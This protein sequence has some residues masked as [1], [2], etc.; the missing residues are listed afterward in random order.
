MIYFDGKIM[1]TNKIA[2]KALK[3][4]LFRIINSEFF[5]FAF[6]HSILHASKMG[7]QA[8]TFIFEIIEKVS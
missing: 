1:I 2:M 3:R 6:V 7:S 5:W 8:S 4:T